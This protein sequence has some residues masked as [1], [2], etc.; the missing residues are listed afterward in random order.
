MTNITVN[1][2]QKT[3]VR[4]HTLL[5]GWK[6]VDH[7]DHNGLNNQRSNLRQATAGQ[8]ARNARIRIAPKTSQYKG[9]AWAGSAWVAYIQADRKRHHLGRSPSELE[10]AYMYDAAARE[11][12]G[13]F[14]CTNFPDQPTQAMRDQWQEERAAAKAGTSQA[15]RDARIKWWAG[16]EPE[17]LACA[18]C[19]VPVQSRAVKRFVYCKK[20][21]ARIS[22]S[23]RKP[24]SR[25][26]NGGKRGRPP[27]SGNGT[28][29]R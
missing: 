1:G 2:R 28:V 7:E 17:M 24:G 20:C 11:L 6:R 12:H 18:S 15:I 29:S 26:V 8:N 14:A 27:L 22:E 5:T 16:R 3:G 19:G 10:A 21:G 4:M 23:Q 25:G 9:V 13:E